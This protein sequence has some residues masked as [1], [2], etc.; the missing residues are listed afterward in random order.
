MKKILILFSLLLFFISC[1]KQETPDGYY[2][3]SINGQA[4]SETEYNFELEKVGT[5][6]SSSKAVCVE[7]TACFVT[8][9]CTYFNG[10]PNC[11]IV[12]VGLSAFPNQVNCG[13]AHV[14][15]ENGTT[16]VILPI[17]HSLIFNESDPLFN[18]VL[19][20]I[21]DGCFDINFG[22]YNMCNTQ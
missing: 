21:Q 16:G 5:E 13:N 1:E 15:I 18:N 6:K 11:R 20:M 2:E 14:V 10:V 4:V 8:T 17:G 3:Y 9:F 7:N 12:R 22:C 19:S